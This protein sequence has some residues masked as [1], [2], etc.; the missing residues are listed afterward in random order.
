MLY[1]YPPPESATGGVPHDRWQCVGDLRCVKECRIHREGVMG[2]AFTT[3]S[4]K[5][6]SVGRDALAKMLSLPPLEQVR[7][8]GKGGGR[9][10][11]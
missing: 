4:G 11:S 3:D 2:V 10:M 6:M 1:I 5:V 9:L 7:G 8:G